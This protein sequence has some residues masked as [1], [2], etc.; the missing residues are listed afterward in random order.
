LRRNVSLAL[1][2]FFVKYNHINDIIMLLTE[3]SHASKAVPVKNSPLPS[4]TKKGPKPKLN[5]VAEKKSKRAVKK[6]DGVKTRPIRQTRARQPEPMKAKPPTRRGGVKAAAVKAESAEDKAVVPEVKVTVPV[7]PTERAQRRSS[8]GSDEEVTASK[9][10]FVES[11]K[12]EEE[13]EPESH[14]NVEEMDSAANAG[15]TPGV[16]QSRRVT[17]LKM[18]AEAE[19]A[20]AAALVRRSRRVTATSEAAAELEAKE[21]PVRRSRRLSVMSEASEKDAVLTELPV[22]TPVRRSRRLS[23][24]SEASEK[25]AVPPPERA[26]P[27]RRSRLRRVS[28]SEEVAEGGEM[29]AESPGPSPAKQSRRASKRSEAANL[30]AAPPKTPV[31]RSRRVSEMVA[32]PKPPAATPSRRSMRI[33]SQTQTSLTPALEAMSCEYSPPPV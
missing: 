5:L 2:V 11:P 33:A 27:V 21:L 19:E 12:T 7:E 9:A 28:E 15:A 1:L 3:F 10:P 24:M 30:D 17:E 20:P 31:R 26:S 23:A 13:E 4:P 18:E 32:S 8:R 6:E 16:R 25:D 29:P 22:A 14:G